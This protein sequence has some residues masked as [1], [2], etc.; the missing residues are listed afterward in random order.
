MIPQSLLGLPWSILP[1]AAQEMISKHSVAP[2]MAANDVV[3]HPILPQVQMLGG[4]AIIPISG[5]IVK[6]VSMWEEHVY[7]L[8]NLH[9]IDQMLDN[10]I[11][12]ASV[13]TVI[14][15]FSSPGGSTVGVESTARKVRDCVNAGKNVIAYTDTVMASAAYF[16]AAGASRI[17]ANPTSVIGSIS[18]IVVAYDY[19]KMFENNGIQVKIFRTGEL[20]GAG[21]MGKPWTPE[22]EAA[23]ERR[24]AYVDGLFKGWVKQNRP[25][26]AEQEMN[27]DWWFAGNAPV[28]AIDALADSIDDLILSL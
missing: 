17:V 16:I 25:A 20:K 26:L 14:L 24:N 5:T 8:C 1:T 4:I 2:Q 11:D 22:E 18:T 28:G 9:R 15:H 6:G 21:T 23:V 13:S 19:S 27:G 3:G 12:D 10:V 7:G